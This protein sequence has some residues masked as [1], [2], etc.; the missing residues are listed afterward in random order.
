V[1][2][3]LVACVMAVVVA[4]AQGVDGVS[5]QERKVWNGQ[6]IHDLDLDDTAREGALRGSLR[7][8]APSGDIGFQA[9]L[10]GTPVEFRSIRVKVVR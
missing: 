1:A 9:H 7:A 6:T 5:A 3:I 10:T 4:Q 8:R 2:V